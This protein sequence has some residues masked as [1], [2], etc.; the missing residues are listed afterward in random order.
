MSTNNF[1]TKS[2]RDVLNA[3]LDE[4]REKNLTKTWLEQNK[5]DPGSAR[6]VIPL[7]VWQNKKRTNDE[8]LKKKVQSANQI[9]HSHH[10]KPKIQP[11]QEAS[12]EI[13]FDSS[14]KNYNAMEE[15]AHFV[16][17][18]SSFPDP[19]M[20]HQM[21]QPS[22]HGVFVDIQQTND[23]SVATEQAVKN[24]P[25]ITLEN[26]D[27][28]DLNI[29]MT[30]NAET[31][32]TANNERSAPAILPQF[33]TPFES[34]ETAEDPMNTQSL[35]EAP[36]GHATESSD[37][38]KMNQTRLETNELPAEQKF[39]TPLDT[40]E[41]QE[42]FISTEISNETS[43]EHDQV[44]ENLDF[45]PASAETPESAGQK[46]VPAEM[47]EDQ[48]S[49]AMA[50]PAQAQDNA[51]YQNLSEFSQEQVVEPQSSI[52]DLS[53][54][55]RFFTKR[56]ISRNETSTLNPLMQNA[57]SVIDTAIHSY[58]GN[59]L[60]QL[61]PFCSDVQLDS[62]YVW[63]LVSITNFLLLFCCLSF[64]CIIKSKSQK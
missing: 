49:F 58:D 33:D 41:A 52:I 27:S 25:D 42:E 24:S 11:R 9:M 51:E 46:D 8:D 20:D 18:T 5:I 38:S 17:N 48:P 30:M 39:D 31:V 22:D 37:S 23:D 10:Y 60:L 6:N 44:L 47:T 1:Q 40:I 13:K 12:K 50:E 32:E 2:S 36:N 64:S 53:F 7:D 3:E 63:S 21:D 16:D 55:F 28:T 54:S 61:E 15:P 35:S 29:G 4:I 43:N 45:N 57:L 34:I 56:Q 26:D 59:V 19:I 14:S 62:K